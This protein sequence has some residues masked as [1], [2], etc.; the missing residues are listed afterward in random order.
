MDVRV[1]VESIEATLTVA[2]LSPVV[3]TVVGIIP[4]RVINFG[5][6]LAP[7]LV[8]SVNGHSISAIAPDLNKVG[9]SAVAA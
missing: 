9:G 1:G 6:S 8:L 3:S 2:I 5:P 4:P 7:S